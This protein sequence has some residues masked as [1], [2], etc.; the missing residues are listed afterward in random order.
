MT[1]PQH[2]Y[3]SVSLNEAPLKQEMSVLFSGEGGPI[4]GHYIGPAV[5][6]YYLIHIVLSGTGK[7]ETLGT[8]VSC[9]RG[10]VFVI[11]PDILVKYEADEHNPWTYAWVAFSGEVVETALRSIGITPDRAIIKNCFES[12]I[13]GLLQGIRAS[14]EEE[15]YPALGNMKAASLLRRIF[16]ELG[17]QAAQNEQALAESKGE[18]VQYPAVQ[19]DIANTA[20]AH[21]YRQ[22][23]QAIRMFSLQYSQQL[24]IESIARTLGYHRAHLTKLFKEATGLSPQ[25][26]LFKTRMKKAEELLQGDL[27]VAQVAASIGY[28]D[29]LF[30]TKQFRKWSGFSPTQYRQQYKE[31]AKQTVD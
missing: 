14:L 29:P 8:S 24:S 10:D 30:F 7:F 23:E 3:F 31:P 6:D 15:L 20:N 16:Y 5:H 4:A 1:I 13:T 9:E 11:F 26:F 25:Q 22:V 27:T 21:T 17:L 12:K 18:Q 2:H 19:L 28:N